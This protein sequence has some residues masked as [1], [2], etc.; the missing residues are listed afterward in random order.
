PRH[1]SLPW[2]HSRIPH[3]AAAARFSPLRKNLLTEVGRVASIPK[4]L[5]FISWVEPCRG[6]VESA[7][8]ERAGDLESALG[9]GAEHG[10]ASLRVPLPRSGDC[11][12]HGAD[13]AAADGCPG[14]GPGHV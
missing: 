2:F 10:T 9:I 1:Q 6:R 14:Q 12:E 3:T 4:K 5:S 7:D 8:A 11:A 13:A